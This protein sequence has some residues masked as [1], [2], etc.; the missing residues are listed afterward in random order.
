MKAILAS[1]F[2][3]FFY[4]VLKPAW[5]AFWY[6]FGRWGYLLWGLFM[7]FFLLI[8]TVTGYRYFSANFPI[9]IQYLTQ[10]II[11]LQAAAIETGSI[12]AK[13]LGPVFTEFLQALNDMLQDG[14]D[15]VKMFLLIFGIVL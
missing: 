15:C 8:L 2:K 4:I 7:L 3:I 10:T 14:Y 5:D 13:L 6:F 12:V 1:P 9:I 11:Y